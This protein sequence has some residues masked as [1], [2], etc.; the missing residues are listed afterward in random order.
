VVDM[1]CYIDHKQPARS[2]SIVRR[3]AS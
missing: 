1:A 2:T 3:S